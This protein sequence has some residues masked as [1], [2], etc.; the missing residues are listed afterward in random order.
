MFSSSLKEIFLA[1]SRATFGC[2]RAAPRTPAR[3]NANN[4]HDNNNN[5]NNENDDNNNN[6]T[7]SNDNN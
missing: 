2:R 5:N 1:P 4:S 6:K 3:S 7:N